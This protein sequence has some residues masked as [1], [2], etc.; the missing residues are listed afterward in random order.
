MSLLKR[1]LDGEKGRIKKTRSVVRT[2]CCGI[3]F[4]QHDDA[5]VVNARG[6]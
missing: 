1:A 2:F 3:A 6:C 5:T 4:G